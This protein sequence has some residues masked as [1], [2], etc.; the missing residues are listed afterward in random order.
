[1]NIS[2]ARMDADEQVR[3]FRA[4]TMFH[5]EPGAAGR[6]VKSWECSF[7]AVRDAFILAWRAYLLCTFPDREAL[8]ESADLDHGLVL[9]LQSELQWFKVFSTWWAQR[10]HYHPNL[11]QVWVDIPCGVEHKELVHLLFCCRGL[12]M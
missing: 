2:T 6:D 12:V 11:G 4:A 1:M 9:H 5:L 10:I 8:W 3:A 7:E